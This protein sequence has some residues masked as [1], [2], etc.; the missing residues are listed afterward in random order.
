MGRAEISEM[1][2]ELL[3]RPEMRELKLPPFSWLYLSLLGNIGNP[4][5]IS[6]YCVCHEWSSRLCAQ[7]ARYENW[8]WKFTKLCGL[9]QRAMSYTKKTFPS[10]PVATC[11]T[12]FGIG[13]VQC[14]E[15]FTKYC[16][17]W[18]NTR[19]ANANAPEIIPTLSKSE[20]KWNIVRH[21]ETWQNELEVSRHRSNPRSIVPGK[22]NASCQDLLNRPK[23]T[24]ATWTKCYACHDVTSD[25]KMDMAPHREN[26]LDTAPYQRRF[27]H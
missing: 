25:P 11:R 21:T 17:P 24:V 3:Q 2:L 19:K 6:K 4:L 22:K 1:R 20:T 5:N 9:K 27:S 14:H 26:S 18:E 13:V 23:R 15:V 7:C 8:Q 16:H 10:L 12:Y